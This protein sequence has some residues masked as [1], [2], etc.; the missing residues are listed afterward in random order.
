MRHW[1]E[2]TQEPMKQPLRRA[3]RG[4]RRKPRDYNRPVLLLQRCSVWDGVALVVYLRQQRGIEAIYHDQA[5]EVRVANPSCYKEAE[6]LTREFERR[7]P[8]QAS[9]R[10][11]ACTRL[12]RR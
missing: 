9:R 6:R 4:I 12:K 11:L 1:D 5:R 8:D 10:E 2:V 3:R 7:Y